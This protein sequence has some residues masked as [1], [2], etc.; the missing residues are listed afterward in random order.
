[1]GVRSFFVLGAYFVL[2]WLRKLVFWRKRGG[3]ARFLENYAPDGIAP[4]TPEASRQLADWLRC[5]NCGLCEAVC[6]LDEPPLQTAHLTFAQLAFSGWRDL[7]AHRL[8]AKSASALA[9]C[10]PCQACE[11]I[12]PERIPLVALAESV[13]SARAPREAA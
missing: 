13:A 6:P 9:D 3:A 8:I 5:T 7:T 10:A 1:L 2:H 4:T 11:R 12:C